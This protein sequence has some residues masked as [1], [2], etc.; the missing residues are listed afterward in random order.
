MV[1]GGK[2]GHAVREEEGEGPSGLE[3]CLM[4]LYLEPC[5]FSL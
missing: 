2:P 1:L 3:R 5:A 4:V